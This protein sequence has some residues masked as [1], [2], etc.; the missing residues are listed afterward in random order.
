MRRTPAPGRWTDRRSPLRLPDCCA[1]RRSRCRAPA[2]SAFVQGK[3][4]GGG[5]VRGKQ[6]ERT[7]ARTM[8]V[9]GRAVSILEHGENGVDGSR[10]VAGF[11]ERSRLGEHVRTTAHARRDGGH[12]EKDGFEERVWKA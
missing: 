11:K 6:R 4:R 1:P 7:C 8:R 12:A 5:A 10:I 9:R 3:P 2:R